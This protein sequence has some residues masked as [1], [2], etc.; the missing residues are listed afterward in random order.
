[1]FDVLTYQKGGAL[2]RMLEQYLG[3]DEFRSGVSHYLRT[4]TY[5]NTETSDLWDAIEE[6]NPST[7]VRRLMDSWIW[8][9]GYPLITGTL[10]GRRARARASSG[11]RYGDTDDADA[12]R[13]AACTCA[14]TASSRKVLL[15]GDEMR[16]PLPSADAAVV[17]NAGG[18]GFV[19]VAYDDDAAGSAG[20]RRRSRS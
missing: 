10:D 1:M 15:D 7:P 14:S 17:V 8:Q 16:V 11:S 20:R 12:V 5:G 9:P 6:A 19:R 13:R 4:H 3:E 2:L 18:H